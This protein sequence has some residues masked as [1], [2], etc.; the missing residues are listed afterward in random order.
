MYNQDM[1]ETYSP[2]EPSEENVNTHCRQYS[3]TILANHYPDK[4]F[5]VFSDRASSSRLYTCPEDPSHVY[6]VYVPMT[7]IMTN[8]DDPMNFRFTQDE[9]T[10]HV[11]EVANTT[12]LAEHGLAPQVYE[13]KGSPS[14]PEILDLEKID[15]DPDG[16][17]KLPQE[18]RIR[19]ADE[20][21]NQ[22]CRLN[23]TAIDM[24]IVYAKGSQ[25]IKIIDC[26]AITDID[27]KTDLLLQKKL[28]YG[29]FGLGMHLVE[30]EPAN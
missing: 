11:N 19:L 25:T 8:P 10:Y 13:V 28:L 22:L 5:Q 30:R 21:F 17:S 6:K 2:K 9:Q 24:E 27:E 15:Y 26:G 29:H 12:L 18:E 1:D 16:L 7:A 23:K 20:L 4:Q 3:E 14:N